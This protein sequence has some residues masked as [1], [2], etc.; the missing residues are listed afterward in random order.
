MNDATMVAMGRTLA[1]IIE[2]YQEPEGIIR[3]PKALQRF[4]GKD[5]IGK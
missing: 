4:L 5:I 2:N 3:V 1:A